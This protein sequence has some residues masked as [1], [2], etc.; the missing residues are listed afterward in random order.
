MH[1]KDNI[2]FTEVG[3]QGTVVEDNVNI[4]H[5]LLF[6]LDTSSTD[7][8]DMQL[9]VE[10]VK[11]LGFLVGA[12]CN[13]RYLSFIIYFYEFTHYEVTIKNCSL[14]IKVYQLIQ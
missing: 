3:E 10:A 13:G 2:F 1:F 5:F 14:Y 6:L 12:T 4:D 9:S 7:V 11:K 8:T